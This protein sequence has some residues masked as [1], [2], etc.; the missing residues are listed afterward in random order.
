MCDSVLV[1][2]LIIRNHKASFIEVDLAGLGPYHVDAL[3]FVIR[4]RVNN[5]LI[6]FSDLLTVYADAI[7]RQFALPLQVPFD[8]LRKVEG[9]FRDTS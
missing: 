7:Y 4:I 5:V 9:F 8:E 2:C 3:E 6:Q 1:C